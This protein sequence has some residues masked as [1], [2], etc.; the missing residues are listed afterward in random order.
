[1]TLD[2]YTTTA[3]YTAE[4]FMMPIFS[5]GSMIGVGGC[6]WLYKLPDLDGVPAH[7]C[8][9]MHSVQ[10]HMGNAILVVQVLVLVLCV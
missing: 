6:E 1:M 5:S 7:S 9:A 4:L 2:L 10:P 3:H 8:D